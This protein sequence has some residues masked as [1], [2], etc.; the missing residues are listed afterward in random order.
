MTAAYEGAVG[1]GVVF[2]A[3]PFVFPPLLAE[4]GGLMMEHLASPRVTPFDG[5]FGIS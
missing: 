2:V 1:G 4:S 5:V 3:C